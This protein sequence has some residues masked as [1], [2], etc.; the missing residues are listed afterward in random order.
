MVTLRVQGDTFEMY[1]GTL[2]CHF[3]CICLISTNIY[4]QRQLTFAE[5]MARCM[6]N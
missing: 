4:E 3:S 1:T 2:L 5:W 6:C